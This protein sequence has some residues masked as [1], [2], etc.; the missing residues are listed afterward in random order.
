[1]GLH[2]YCV[3]PAPHPVPDDCTGLDGVRPRAVPA[4]GLA[5]W[6]TGH[7]EPVAASIAALRVHNR[8]VSAA[9]TTEVTPVPVRFGQWFATEAEAVDRVRA[10]GAKWVGLLG[11]FAGRA[12]YGIR[13][14]VP[15]RYTERDVH[16]TA[17]E[18]GR[19]YM[20]ALARKQAHAVRRR[21]EAERIAEL[22]EARAGGLVADRRVEHG[23]AGEQL[24]S[25]AHLVAWSDTA[26]YHGAT[27][28]ISEALGEARI[29]LTGPWPPYSFVE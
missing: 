1:M 26:A 7:D 8:V 17:V 28:G 13:V 29:V 16:T 18:S 22:I 2:V 24:V 5:L 9:M 3:V 27:E 15:D 19:E 6:V 4:D 12:E 20:A 10:D 21:A 25:V 23:G 14:M 11:R